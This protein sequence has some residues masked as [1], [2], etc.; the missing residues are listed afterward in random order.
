MKIQPGSWELAINDRLDSPNTVATDQDLRP[1]ISAALDTV[2]GPG[3]YS[4]EREPD[5]QKRYGFS[6]RAS[7]ITKIDDLFRS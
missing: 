5:P 4:I 2:F 7:Q 1:E 3:A 6:I